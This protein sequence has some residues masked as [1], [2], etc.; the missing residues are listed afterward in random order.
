MRRNDHR[1]DSRPF[2]PLGPRPIGS[3]AAAPSQFPSNLNSGCRGGRF[4]HFSHNLESRQR[5]AGGLKVVAARAEIYQQPLGRSW[6][7]GEFARDGDQWTAEFFIGR[8]AS[9]IETKQ[10]LR[11]GGVCILSN[12]SL[13]FEPASNGPRPEYITRK[14]G[15]QVSHT[16]PRGCAR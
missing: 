3:G 15:P 9:G 13:D 12:T 11:I 4:R 7:Q 8:P 2:P 5:P 10:R 6:G 16:R 1:P 14:V